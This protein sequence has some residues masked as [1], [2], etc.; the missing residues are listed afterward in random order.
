MGIAEIENLQS[1]HKEVAK[2]L[3]YFEAAAKKAREAERL[4][5]VKLRRQG[6]LLQDALK[7]ADAALKQNHD[8]RLK[9]NSLGKGLADLSD[10]EAKKTTNRL[11]DHLEGWIKRHYGYLQLNNSGIAPE[12]N[13]GQ[14]R[15]LWFNIY[16][17]LSQ[18]IFH[19]ILSRFIVGTGNPGMNQALR[20]LDEK[21]Q[22]LCMSTVYRH[23]I[24]SI[25][26]SNLSRPREYRPILA[27]RYK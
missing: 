23:T 15:E 12:V 10:E 3:D 19:I 27:C 8:L 21:V 9:L 2:G 5:N 25:L 1:V 4:S 7:S 6:E 17:D 13:S 24:R 18:Q 11:Y 14:Q 20:M 22:E 26:L 16:G